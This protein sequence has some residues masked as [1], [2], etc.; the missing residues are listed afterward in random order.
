MLVVSEEI[1]CMSFVSKYSQNIASTETSGT[2]ANMAP[3]NELVF[4]NSD[5]KTINAAVIANLV[6]YQVIAINPLIDPNHKICML[7]T[8]Y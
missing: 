4:D 3:A 8:L 5:I 1:C 7:N 6:R 2:E